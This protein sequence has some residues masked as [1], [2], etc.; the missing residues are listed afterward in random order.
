M[1]H[2]P[3]KAF[4]TAAKARGLKFTFGSHARDPRAGA[5]V[6]GRSVAEA[7]GLTRDDFYEP[8][9]HS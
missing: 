6:C 3:H 4:I 7:C 9:R 2:V 1:A 5:M 8:G